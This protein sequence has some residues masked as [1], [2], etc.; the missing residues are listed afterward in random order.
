LSPPRVEGE[1]TRCQACGNGTMTSKIIKS[2]DGVDVCS[3]CA[4][5]FGKCTYCGWAPEKLIVKQY[6]HTYCPDCGVKTPKRLHIRQKQEVEPKKNIIG[7]RRDKIWR[8][9]ASVPTRK[10]S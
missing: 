9:L 6:V 10:D 8:T 3:R 5:T 2:S 4:Q 1:Y 7:E